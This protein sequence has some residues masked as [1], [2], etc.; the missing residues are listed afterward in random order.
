M[1][2]YKADAITQKPV[3]YLKNAKQELWE[4]FHEK[5]PNPNGVKRNFL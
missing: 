3:L 4:K 5:Y 2:S 1:S